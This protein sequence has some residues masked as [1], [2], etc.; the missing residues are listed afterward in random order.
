[1]GC[2]GEVY[3]D[4]LMVESP[5]RA[6][7]AAANPLMRAAAAAADHLSRG[8]NCAIRSS[9]CMAR[10]AALRRRPNLEGG[11]V[12]RGHYCIIRPGYQNGN[13]S[14]PI[15][16]SQWPLEVLRQNNPVLTCLTIS[17]MVRIG[18]TDNVSRRGI[19]GSD[20]TA[21]PLWAHECGTP[22]VGAS[23]GCANSTDTKVTQ[24][25]N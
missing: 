17:R 6:P 25:E 20:T 18:Q 13:S 23:Q 8:A 11:G 15:S 4:C 22:V 24:S 1:M 9:I 19:M 5:G 14:E 3:C 10:A 16:F 12:G 21:H 2:S 7:A